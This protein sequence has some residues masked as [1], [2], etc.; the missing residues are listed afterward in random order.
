MKHSLKEKRKNNKRRVDDLRN[1]TTE[2]LNK[3]MNM[4]LKSNTILCV[5]KKKNPKGKC[6]AMR[7]NTC[8]KHNIYIYIY[9]YRYIPFTGTIITIYIYMITTRKKEV[10]FIFNW[11]DIVI[12]ALHSYHLNYITYFK[13]K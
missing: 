7:Q 1:S 8:T 9:I 6:S 10:F 4:V 3:V 2:I 13:S 11:R 12:S 5:K